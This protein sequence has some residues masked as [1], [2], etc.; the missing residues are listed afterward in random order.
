MNLH[1]NARLTPKGRELLIQRLE[2]GEHPEDLACAMGV[3]VRTVYKWR[4][5]YREEGLSGL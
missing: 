2:R 1:K 3:N 4:L 5:P